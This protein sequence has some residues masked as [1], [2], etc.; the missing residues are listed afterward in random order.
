MARCQV[1]VI[2]FNR[3]GDLFINDTENVTELTALPNKEI[4]NVFSGN[5]YSI[6][7][8]DNFVECILKEFCDHIKNP[9]C[10]FTDTTPT[11]NQHTK[12]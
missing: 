6:Y 4:S 9:V 5:A 10:L 7:T 2:G 3:Y 1:F 11:T 12:W 8:D